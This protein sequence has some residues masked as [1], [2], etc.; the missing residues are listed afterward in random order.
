M[1]EIEKAAGGNPAAGKSIAALAG[2][3]A[4]IFG[5]IDGHLARFDHI[6]AA[7]IAMIARAAVHGNPDRGIR[8]GAEAEHAA[9]GGGVEKARRL[10]AEEFLILKQVVQRGAAK[11][12]FFIG[13]C[14]QPA[15]PE[16]GVQIADGS[17]IIAIMDI[18]RIHGQDFRARRERQG[19][20]QKRKKRRKQAFHHTPS[21][22]QL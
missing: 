8:S 11:A 13:I 6:G 5:A 22:I 9:E 3:E 4:E 19:K 21:S 14:I 15:Q 7:F 10:K 17:A 18:I 16:D 12:R 2:R 1:A 20:K